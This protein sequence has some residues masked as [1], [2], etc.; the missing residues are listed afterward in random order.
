MEKP[1]WSFQEDAVDK[2]MNEFKKDPYSKNLLV[3]PTGG[4]KTIV[5]MK[6]ISK[7]IKNDFIKNG[8]RVIWA[9]HLKQLKKQ[10]EDKALEGKQRNFNTKIRK[11][12]E[13]EMK[14]AAT[15][16]L[17]NDRNHKYKLLIIDEAHHSAA[18]SYKDFFNREIGILGLTATPNRTDEV[19]L[20]FDRTV[21]EITFQE[22]IKRNI[23]IK[24]KFDT[25]KTGEKIDIRELDSKNDEENNKF[26][27]PSRNQKI[28]KILLDNKKKY[29]KVIVFAGTIKHVKNLYEIIKQENSFRGEPYEHIGYI[30]SNGN[31]KGIDNNQY[32]KWHKKIKS[33]ILINCGVLTEG[34]DDRTIN[35]AV[36]AVPT[37]STLH[38]MQCVG[39]VVRNPEEEGERDIYVVELADDLPNINYRID[40]K[41]L[42]ADI[43]EYLEP[44]ILEEEYDN[45]KLLHNKI[46]EIF[47]NY[48]VEKTYLK[49]IGSLKPDNHLR[50]LLFTANSNIDK[51]TI[52]KPLII[53]KSNKDHYIK[54]FNE[55]SNNIDKYYKQSN[56]YIFERVGIKKNDIYFCDRTFTSDFL[57]ALK[58]A[59]EE[60]NKKIKITRLKYI[61][62]NKIEEVINIPEKII[63][64]NE[65]HKPGDFKKIKIDI[66]DL[67]L[68]PN[69]P[70]FSRHPDEVISD[71]KID[72]RNIQEETFK[73][74]FDRKLHFNIEDLAN[75]IKTKGFVK[76]DNLFVKKI[77]NKYLVIEGNRRISAVKFLLKEHES[78]KKASKLIKELLRDISKIECADLTGK[79]T[80]EIRFILSLR[81]QG[82]IK[83]WDLLPK[84]LDIWNMYMDI[85]CAEQVLDTNIPEAFAF[86]KAIVGKVAIRNSLKSTDV[87]DRLRAYRA[88]LQLRDITEFKETLQGSFSILFEALNDSV[89]REKYKFDEISFTF[90]EE[91]AERFLRLITGTKDFEPVITGAAA[92]KG[93]LRDY[94]RVL[95]N[96]T[97]E[98][99]ERIEKFGESPE[100]VWADVNTRRNIRDLH[101]CLEYALIELRKIK[102]GED[103]EGLGEGEKETLKNIQGI[104]EKIITLSRKRNK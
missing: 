3:I 63:E 83:E 78:G 9:T 97:L 22:L 4:G 104:I 66:K 72:A 56:L 35:T 71:D 87:R 23:I 13:I 82:S 30:I 67:L 100:N 24:P 37:K 1:D 59:Y 84:S 42:F 10:T 47:K 5:A 64:K 25:F 51:N 57:I 103:F 6:I 53:T 28:A 40:N 26:N 99:L 86:D 11:Y 76:V 19:Q 68:D 79:S 77:K 21:Y 81:H 38:Y 49:K 48:N 58:K 89:F 8:D 90:P 7:L 50:I 17:R 14:N 27:N 74:M 91:M 60:K 70:R 92:G 69:N 43:S 29:K 94:L 88:Y 102:L 12:L 32:L 62:F 36:M 98:D 2:L 46:N 33:S 55:L 34:Y 41:W 73:R 44:I 93:T 18:N 16:K 85:Y 52:W 96:G 54:I 61:V 39:R 75:S 65:Y 20:K 31:E 45:K 101:H 80:Q 95:K 15:K